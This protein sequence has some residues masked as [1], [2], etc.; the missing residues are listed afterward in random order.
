MKEKVIKIDTADGVMEVFITVPEEGGP[1]PAVILFIDSIGVREELY[2]MCRR[3][4]TV[5]Y[6][7]AMPNL[8]YRTDGIDDVRIDADKISESGPDKTRLWNLIKSID[9]DM[10]VSDTKA[11]LTALAHEKD[12]APPPYGQVGYCMSGQFVY[13]NAGRLAESFA[14][15]MSVYGAGHITNL[16]QS[17]HL[18]TKQITGEIEFTC[19]EI[20]HWAPLEQI[21]QLRTLLRVAG[22]KHRI[23]VYPGAIHG[24]AFPDRA[25]YNKPAA[26]RHWERLFD[27]FDRTLRKRRKP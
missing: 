8:Y 11:L 26:E 23:D 27:L 22:V 14:A 18:T 12:A 1:H 7:V 5:G 10:V 16:P 17:P 13:A 21:E 19:A 4:G 3:I 25:V 2:D 9:N 24:F 6:F 20:D 15:T